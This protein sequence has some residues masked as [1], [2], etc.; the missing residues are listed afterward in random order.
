MKKTSFVLAGLAL[1]CAT[2]AFADNTDTATVTVNGTIVSALTIANGT[3]V[4][5]NVVKPKAALTAG[6]AGP[7]AGTSTVAVT[8]DTAGVATIAYGAGANPYAHGVAAAS[9]VSGSS[10]NVANG[11]STATCAPMVVTGQSGYFFLTTT[12]A[13][14]GF[15]AGVSA[16][17]T[18]CSP[19]TGNTVLTAGTA[20]IYCGAAIAVTTAAATGAYSGSFPVTVTYD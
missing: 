20:T 14:T 9:T 4:M 19:G 2:P 18:T 8:C 11:G 7:T 12:G 16:T 15:P 13:G 1:I 5:P 6:G 17:A 10:A 3:L